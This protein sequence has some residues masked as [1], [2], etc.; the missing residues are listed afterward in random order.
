MGVLTLGYVRRAS[1]FDYYNWIVSYIDT[2]CMINCEPSLLLAPKKK[3]IHQPSTD[4][5]ISASNR[6][7]LLRNKS[8]KYLQ[9]ITK[10]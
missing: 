1:V 8:P 2:A 4:M 9:V 3:T 10:N 5:C 6:F 7:K